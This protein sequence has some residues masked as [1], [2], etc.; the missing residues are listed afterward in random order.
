MQQFIRIRGARE[1]NLKNVD[2]DIPKNRLVVITGLSGSGK[3]T[4][5][6][7]T[8]YAEGQR[9]YVESLSAYARQFLNLMPRPAVDSID[10][11]SPSISIEQKTISKNPRSTVGTITEIYDY[12]RLLYARI[13]IPFS[14]TTGLPIRAQTVS[15]I[16]DAILKYPAG[17]KLYILSPM[18]RSRKGEFKND[19]MAIKR[20]G[21][22]RV[23]V[24]GRLYLI[25]EVP[26]LSKNVKHDI[27]II[28][29]RILIPT[30]SDEI[31]ELRQR[32]A[33]SVP[34]SL[35][36]SGGL[37][38]TKNLENNKE[39][40]FSENF[41]CPVSGFCIEKIEPR[42]FSFNNPKGACK[43]CRGIGFSGPGSSFSGRPSASD[44]DEDP[45]YDILMPKEVCHVCQGTRLSA[46]ALSIK[47]DS[48]NIA[49]VSNMSIDSVMDWIVQLQNKLDQKEM[50]IAGKVLKEV[51][52]RLQFLVN[53]GLEYLTLSRASAT[54]S[55][56]E[57]QRIRLAS[58]IGSGLTGVMYVLDE[59]SIGLHQRDNG[60]LISTLKKLRDYNNSVI[61]V[62]HDEDAMYASDWIID[63]GPRAGVHG[64]QICACGT[65]EEIKNNPNSLTGDYLSGRKTIEVPKTRRW[66]NKANGLHIVGANANN[67]K[68]IN[69]KIPQNAFVCVTGVSGSGK[70]TLIIN[71]LYA[72]IFSK[73]NHKMLSI[74]GLQEIKNIDMVDKAININQSPIGRTPRS[75]PATYVGCFSDIR[76]LYADLPESRA[77]GYSASRFSFNIKG[78]RCEACKGDG[79]IKVEMHFLPDVYVMCDQCAGSRFNRETQEIKYKGKSISDVL[80]MTIEDGASL[81]RNQPAIYQKL[82]CLC[83][84]G[85]G[86]LTI[87]QKATTL[88]GGEAQRVKLAKELSRRSTGKTMYILD[89][90]TTGLH[91]D[92]IKKLLEILHLLVDSGNSVI[93]IEHNMDVI[94]TADWIIDIGP[95]GGANG[96]TIVIEGPP[97]V[98]AQCE[99]SYTGRYLAKYL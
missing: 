4:L 25:D 82:H 71:I 87:G 30:E 39:R 44:G 58:Q 93:V 8:L 1:H 73:M 64:G 50:A 99:A 19:L 95:E 7:D 81:F 42:L 55:G 61:V 36:N 51:E 53:V 48:K 41:A 28:V 72:A 43:S 40:I 10:G 96:G 18:I 32:L 77:R 2:L 52:N 65:I 70:S 86:Y 46:E 74:K 14:P 12:L 68:N 33:N 76:A 84:V 22:E 85:L 17:T 56:G 26:A 6:F 97:E 62:E 78:G 59:P 47:I 11:L 3:S 29:D 60:R 75:N 98:I 45:D 79:V 35:R 67:L 69:V 54:L 57:S 9:R 15:Q 34:V 23:F 20:A 90:P 66:I 24:D 21:F 80:D 89:E 91:M 31:D 88:S 83:K 37:L 16:I 92:D 38:I 94:K 13:G 63:M 5:A 27:S 49:E